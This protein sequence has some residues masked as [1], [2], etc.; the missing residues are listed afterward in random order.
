MHDPKQSHLC[1]QIEIS[2]VKTDYSCKRTVRHS[3]KRTKTREIR[4]SILLGYRTG[5]FQTL[6]VSLNLDQ[7]RSISSKI[8]IS[9]LPGIC[10]YRS[11]IKD[12]LLEVNVDNL[13]SRRS[14][15]QWCANWLLSANL[16]TQMGRGMKF[17]F[18]GRLS[19]DCQNLSLQIQTLWRTRYSEV[20][21]NKLM[22]CPRHPRLVF[23][24]RIAITNNYNSI[25]DLEMTACKSKA[26]FTSRSGFAQEKVGSALLWDRRSNRRWALPF[27]CMYQQEKRTPQNSNPI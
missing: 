6:H 9:N 25:S 16:S 8:S 4:E 5:P 13:T 18:L 19:V 27:P 17:G 12:L 26:D 2:F 14:R 3:M 15:R 10:R 23:S 22:E 20:T 7:P 24:G 21:Q 11:R 1:T